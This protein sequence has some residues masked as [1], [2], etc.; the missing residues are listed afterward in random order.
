[1][2]RYVAAL[3]VLLP[4]LAA[5]PPIDKNKTLGVATAPVQI[6][7][8]SDF[9]CP[10]CKALHETVLPQLM[11]DYVNAGKVYIIDRSFPLGGGPGTGH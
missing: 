10:H 9:T 11:K 4:C 8:F 3:M 1:M 7:I 2:K 6:E 5:V